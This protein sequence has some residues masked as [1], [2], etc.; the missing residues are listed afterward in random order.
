MHEMLKLA[1]WDRVTWKNNVWRMI[2]LINKSDVE[3]MQEEV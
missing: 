3:E 2:H 1:T